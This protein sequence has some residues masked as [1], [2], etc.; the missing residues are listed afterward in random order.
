MSLDLAQGLSFGLGGGYW[1]F[2]ITFGVIL[3]W[4]IGDPAFLL[5]PIILIG[6]AIGFLNKIMNK[7]SN[8]RAKGVALLIIVVLF[9]ALIV[10][11]LQ[12]LTYQASF[13][14][15]TLLNI[16]LITMALAAKTLAQEVM[17]VL[18]VLKKGDLEQSRIQ[19][20]YLV[21]RDT[22]SLT[23]KEIIRATIETT[24]E[25]TI[26][27]V[28]AP[29]FYLFLG[30]LLPIPWLNPVVL[31][32]AYKAVN[33]LDSMVGYIQEPYREFG[34]AS[35]IFDDII[36]FVPARLGSFLMLVAGFFLG[37]S[38]KD[39]LA[40]FRRDRF[41]HKSPNSAHPESV[42]AGLL[43]IQLGGTNHYFGQ[44]LEKPTIGVAKTPLNLLDIRETVGIM[45]ASE[46]VTMV[47]GI[48][49]GVVILILV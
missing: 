29:I 19:V 49:V 11:G 2:L 32:M 21:G 17:K 40:V 4:L 28:L 13:I 39:G 33:T 23:E 36:N 3:D 46:I 22:Q 27:G 9:T 5:H 10:V 42:V 47:L 24:A 7:G 12:W 14:L 38:F 34:A 1:L 26:D 20:G 8:R 41:N 31:V 48:A 44:V 25:N 18:R 30:A 35:A 37:Y 6:K 43:G 15:Y 45:Y 16:Y